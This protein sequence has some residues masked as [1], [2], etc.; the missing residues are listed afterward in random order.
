MSFLCLNKT[1][2]KKTE[3]FVTKNNES[4]KPKNTKINSYKNANMKN[5]KKTT[6]NM[7]V[8]DCLNSRVETNTIL[9]SFSCRIK[10]YCVRALKDSGSQQNFIRS[11]LADKL[12]LKTIKS[13]I[14]LLINGINVSRKYQTRLVELEISIG[15]NKYV[16]QVLCLPDITVSL[17][18][19]E[20]GEITKILK[21]LNFP[22][23]DKLLETKDK[24]LKDF[25]LILGVQTAYCIPETEIVIGGDVKSVLG[26]TPNGIIL[27]G[28]AQHLLKNV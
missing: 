9:P 16:I 23:A 15:N 2:I 7:V 13:N 11:D 14:E 25:Q 1:E 17:N 22:L 28:N 21:E 6:N 26:H 8:L 18:I 24:K 20:I 27:K 12:K 19:P 10:N 5:K 4:V 3:N